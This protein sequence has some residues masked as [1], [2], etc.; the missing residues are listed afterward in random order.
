MEY[1]ELPDTAALL[2]VAEMYRADA[3]AMAGGVSGMTLMEAAGKAVA[4]SVLGRT[5]G[6]DPIAVLC[7][8][9]NNGGDGFITARLLLEA[10][11]RVRL[12]LLGDRARLVGDA[13]TAAERWPGEVEALSPALLDGAVMAVD[14]MFGAGLTRDVDGVAGAVVEALVR[15]ALPVVAV[16]VP[17][18]V[19]GDTGAVRGVAAPAVETVCFFRRK[20]GHLLLPGRDLCGVLT[21][22]DIGI[23]KTVLAAIKPKC[24]ANSPAIWGRN[25]PWPRREGHKYSRGKVVVQGGE[26]ATGAARLAAV[27]A[28]RIGAGVVIIASPPKAAAVYRA[29]VASLM[30]AEIGDS[31]G[32]E[33]LVGDARVTG[34]LVGP[35]NGL[36]Q[37]TCERT[38]IALATG[39]SCV[40]DADAL[41]VFADDPGRLFGAISGGCVLTPHEGEFR[42]LFDH[43]AAA[44]GAGKVTRVRA[45]AATSG[46]VVLLK[47]ADTV[48]A[49]GRGMAF[50]NENAPATLA[51]AG[52]G[53]VL[54]G[55]ITGLM[56]QGMPP[57]DS[58][59]A[60]VWLHGA[61]AGSFGLGLIAD[62][63]VD[64]LPAALRGLAAVLGT[65]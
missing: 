45:A 46:G 29:G 37:A 7:G 19:D 38:L 22:A 47:G 27:A 2:S 16:D 6:D 44:P 1:E 30:V 64:H 35:G 57:L 28:L 24:F 36:S 25:F 40:L 52:A 20:P 56:A 9:G 5:C 17:S 49:D 8:P 48:I 58:A 41:T 11:R 13:A 43:E 23:P 18:G 32:F 4:E 21:L 63:L 51:T 3:A 12:G 61:A 42:R 34:M 15:L 62:D 14:A 55:M 59:G 31:A 39:R 65:A 33:S 26:S 54:A 50:I 53:D 10:G 60:S